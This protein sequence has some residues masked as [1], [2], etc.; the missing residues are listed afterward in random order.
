MGIA[1]EVYRTCRETI[2]EHGG[3]RLQGVRLAVGELSAVEPSLLVSA[4][5]AVVIDSPDAGA[6]LE[7]RWCPAQQFCSNCNQAKDRSEGSWMR[8]C[9]DCGFPVQ[10]SGGGE[11]DV[12]DLTFEGDELVDAETPESMG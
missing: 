9:P 7:I 10:V 8:V 6:E 1:L 4:W 2:E 5:E 3:G 11:L 12:L